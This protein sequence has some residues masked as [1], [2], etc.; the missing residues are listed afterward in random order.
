MTTIEAGHRARWFLLGEEDEIGPFVPGHGID[1]FFVAHPEVG[2][3]IGP[4][5]E[6][7][8]GGKIRA[9]SGGVVTWTEERGAELVKALEH[10]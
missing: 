10:T 3:P 4:E 6:L 2:S 7:D 5:E 1:D 9:F 8:G